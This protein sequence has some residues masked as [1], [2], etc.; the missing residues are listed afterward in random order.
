MDE[1]ALHEPWKFSRKR[2]LNDMVL[3]A[4]RV[5][6]AVAKFL[7]AIYTVRYLG[8]AELGIFG[9]LT[10]AV[11]IV[12]AL[13]GLGMTQWIMRKIVD[14]PRPQALQLMASRLSLILLI[15]LIIQPIALAVN[16]ALG[17]QLPL[18]IALL[19][20]AIVLLDN[21]SNE[22]TDMLMAR[23]HIMLAYWLSCVRGGVWPYPVIAAGILFPEART[24]EFLLLGW[25]GTLVALW[26]IIV[27]LVIPEGRWRHLRPRVGTLLR[28]LHGSL[29]L[30]VKDVSWTVSMF[31]DRFI[32]SLLLGLELT[33]VYT[34]FWSIAN[35]VHSLSVNGVLQAQLPQIIST[36]QT[37]TRRASVRS[38]GA[39]RSRPALGRCCS[40]SPRPQQCLWCCP[41][42]ISRC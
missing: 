32:I 21:L 3:V 13:A 1:T 30:Y 29:V 17:Q 38:S 5:T 23:G 19:C 11:N 10:G 8:L 26:V 4:M 9:L 42:W 14:L 25:F 33:G 41:S 22:A 12:P 18:H 28:D 6:A 37:G 40:R 16:L 27:A 34:L 7:L 36:A 35:V 15:H 31:V 20:G 39:S 2:L 24:L